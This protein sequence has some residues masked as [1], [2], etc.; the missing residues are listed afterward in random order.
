MES[1]ASLRHLCHVGATLGAE[2][3]RF[4]AIWARSRT[5]LAAENLYLR[6]QFALYRERKV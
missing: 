6:K 3:L 5:N 1:I 2:A 4:I